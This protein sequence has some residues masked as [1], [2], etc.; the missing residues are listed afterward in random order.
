MKNQ[1][2]IIEKTKALLDTHCYEGLRTAA[3]DWLKA[4]GTENEKK[5]S[6]KYVAE[7]EDAI[8]D[9]DTVIN[10]FSSEEGIKKFGAKQAGEIASHAKEIKAKGEKWCDCPA[11]TAAKEVLKYKEDLLA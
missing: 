10:L 8:V 3:Q 5:A 2:V 1:D 11:C 9:I 4:V 7:L 6:E